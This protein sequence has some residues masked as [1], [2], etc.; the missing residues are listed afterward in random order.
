MEDFAKLLEE[1]LNQKRKIEPGSLHLC[2]VLRD[3]GGFFFIRTKGEHPIE[4]VVGKEEF[5]EEENLPKPGDALSLYFLWENSGDNIFTYCLSGDGITNATLNL[6]LQHGIPI[7]GQVVQS[8]QDGWIV[9]LGGYFGFC[10][11]SQWEKD[12]RDLDLVGRKFKFAVTFLERKKIR[13]S[14]RKISEREREKRLEILRSSWEEGKYVTGRISSIHKK[15][16]VVEIEGIQ[17]FVPASEASLYPDPD[18]TKE[19]QIGEII[20]GKILE[21]NPDRN[22]FR[23]GIRDFLKDRSSVV[24]PFQEGDILEGRIE[25]IKPFGYFIRLDENFTGLVPAREVEKLARADRGRAYTPGEKVKVFVI[26]VNPQK[27]Q[28]TL[29]IEKAKELEDRLEY[30]K[31]LV[32]EEEIGSTGSLGWI[33]KKS[34][35]AKMK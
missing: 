17:A 19:F 9:K 14:Q 28:I 25:R 5:S 4:G 10:P 11:T 16:L 34:L 27:R 32:S 15:G 18:L 7:R 20:Q 13:L 31:Y 1:N 21:W 22:R 2:T 35:D 3:F 29:S 30:E 6:A 8:Q 26:E 24:L 12:L 33:L 23:I